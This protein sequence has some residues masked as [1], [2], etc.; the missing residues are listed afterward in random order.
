VSERSLRSR[1]DETPG[2]YTGLPYSSASSS[3]SLIQPQGS[4]AEG[5]PLVGCK[6]LMYH[7]SHSMFKTQYF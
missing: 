4:A 5:C 2:L 7:A 6:Y 3:F 1:L